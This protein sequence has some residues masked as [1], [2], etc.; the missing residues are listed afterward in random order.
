VNKI[1][2]EVNINASPQTVWSIMDDLERYPEWNQVVPELAGLTMVG[3]ILDAKIAPPNSPTYP[4]HPELL[5]VIGARELRWKTVTDGFSAEHYFILTPTT[6]GGTHIL[7]NEEFSGTHADS[8]F[9]NI[10]ASMRP[11]Y[12]Q[13]NET[14]KARAEA[15]EAELLTLHPAVDHAVATGTAPP[16]LTLRC[17]CASEPVEVRIDVKFVHNHLCGCTQCWKPAGAR[18]AQTAAVPLGALC[19]SE[20]GNKLAVADLS[21][22][23]RRNACQV[24]GVHMFGRVDDTSHHFYGLDFIHPELAV[25]RGAPA[26]EFAGFTSSIIEAAQSPSSM[27][28]VRKRLAHLGIPSYDAFS[29]EL[30]DIIA[31]HKVKMTGRPQ[32]DK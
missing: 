13:M 14:L 16:N 27:Y 12:R 31:W 5:R 22:S 3:E 25:E 28:A 4:F 17:H 8:L 26:P 23:I 20:N 11:L 10:E 6:S 32:N 29:P 2:T 1:T 19:V 24:C 21:K 7:H 18:F 15:F 30:M 9:P